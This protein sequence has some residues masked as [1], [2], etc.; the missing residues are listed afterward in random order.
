M[1]VAR[2]GEKRKGFDEEDIEASLL[3]EHDDDDPVK[4]RFKIEEKPVARSFQS[5][6]N[7]VG[8]VTTVSKYFAQKKSD[9]SDDVV[10]ESINDLEAS[11]GEEE[12]AAMKTNRRSS[13]VSGDWF[14]SID[15]S[16][17]HQG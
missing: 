11:D 8:N 14:G 3:E 13:N 17:S 12:G 5:V 10:K 1:G 4:K 2:K 6:E 9:K 7:S 16:A 15:A